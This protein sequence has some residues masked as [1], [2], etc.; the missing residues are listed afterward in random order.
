M[1]LKVKCSNCD[2][3]PWE[4]ELRQLEK[5]VEQ[6][7]RE[8]VPCMYSELGCKANLL[9]A[10]AEEHY[11]KVNHLTMAMQRIRLLNNRIEKL[12][13]EV[14]KRIPPIVFKM[15]DIEYHKENEIDWDSPP[16][17]SHAK[18]YK[19][20]LKVESDDDTTSVYVCLMHGEFDDNLVWPF[21]GV[22]L[23]EILNQE[24]DSDHKEGMARFMERKT[25]LKNRKVP[26]IE[27]KNTIGWGM[28]NF[29]SE[30]EEDDYVVD[31]CMYLRVS[32]ITVQDMNKPWLI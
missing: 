21:R 20:Y 9:K 4:G 24:S 7:S 1:S 2:C 15:E 23:F 32:S 14:G 26:A 3:C 30:D 10:K 18:G 29:L 5:H 27:G 17:Y 16:F 13:Q 19:F 22:I 28:D 11:S 31:D 6:C 12:E 25:S 8:T